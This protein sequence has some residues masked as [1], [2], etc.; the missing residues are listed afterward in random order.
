VHPSPAFA[1]AGEGCTDA[2]AEWAS[3]RD[4]AEEVSA[5]QDLEKA[6]AELVESFSL[7]AD[8]Y[9]KMGD[10]LAQ[11]PDS[12]SDT[13][14]L[15][16]LI[17]QLNALNPD[18]VGETVKAKTDEWTETVTGTADEL[19]VDLPGWFEQWVEDLETAGQRLESL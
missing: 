8:L 9:G 4:S 14:E 1:K 7:E 5:P 11:M 3:A 18:E 12:L 15:S 13:A 19:G 10:V 6:H 2:S 17:A 16:E